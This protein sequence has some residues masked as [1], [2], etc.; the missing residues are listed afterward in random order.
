M[1]IELKGKKV[2]FYCQILLNPGR[3][4]LRMNFSHFY[5]GKK[6]SYLHIY[7]KTVQLISG[8][9]GNCFTAPGKVLV[10]LY[11]VHCP[12][13]KQNFRDITRS[14][15]ENEILNEIFRIV[16]RFPR[17]ILCYFKKNRLPLGQ[18]VV[19]I[20]YV[21]KWI[22]KPTSMCSFMHSTHTK[23]NLNLRVKNPSMSRLEQM[24]RYM[25]GI[26]ARYAL[27][28]MYIQK[29]DIQNTVS[30]APAGTC[31]VFTRRLLILAQFIFNWNNHES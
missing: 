15:E 17:D 20:T 23:N 9:E 1:W 25:S 24:Q 7:I 5:R 29:P 3:S 8:S 26:W 6:F 30:S 2:F 28:S 12:K 31:S 27:C 22:L 19:R 10:Q 14:V 18:C 4:A 21:Y 11:Q 13:G 16:S